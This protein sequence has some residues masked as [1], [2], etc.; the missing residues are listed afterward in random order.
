[1]SVRHSFTSPLSYV[2]YLTTGLGHRGSTTENEAKAA[3]YVRRM[4]L[5]LHVP[6]IEIQHFRGAVKVWRP[7]IVCLLLGLLAAAVYPLA[8]TPGR[9]LATVLSALGL[10][11]LYREL[12]FN[13]N[14]LRRLLPQ[15]NSQNVI[16]IVPPRVQTRSRVV[17]IGHLDSGQTPLLFSSPWTLPVFVALS[18]TSAFFLGLNAVFYLVATVSGQELWYDLSWL[19]TAVQGVTLL[20]AVEGELSPYTQGANDNAAAVGVALSMAERAVETPFKYTEVWVLMS[21]CE[22]V[23]CYGISHFLKE[24]AERLKDA[25]FINL[26]GVGSGTLHYS[27]REG[28]LKAYHS[29]PQ[30]LAIADNVAR[31]RPELGEKGQALSAGYTETGVIAKSGLRGITLLALR[32]NRLF[33]YLPYWHRKD[34]TFDKLDEK[35]VNR[36]GEFVWDMIYEVDRLQHKE[37]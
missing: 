26:E 28:M 24:Y 2:E 8:G 18:V 23:G 6:Q 13:D 12:N 35:T 20:F 15:A 19:G 17:V 34:D 29:D 3:E 9:L 16:G 25:H 32:A 14:W 11:W 36:V 33:K 27:T 22:E 21:G 30:L 1:M 5:N 37:G 31:R 7:Y 4:L 10:W